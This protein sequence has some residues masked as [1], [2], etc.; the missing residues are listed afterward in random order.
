MV[1]VLFKWEEEKLSCMQVDLFGGQ[2]DLFEE[3]NLSADLLKGLYVEMKFE[4]PSKIQTISLP[5]ILNPPYKHLIAQ[6]H[7]GSGKTTC[8]VLGMLSRVDPKLTAPQALCICPT[9]ELVIQMVA[10]RI[11]GLNLT[12]RKMK[13]WLGSGTLL[14]VNGMEMLRI[15]KQHLRQL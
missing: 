4:R 1:R 8:F 3:L 2:A 5:M 7:N 10:G 14:L 9:R 13:T 11:G 12:G 6:A 15:K